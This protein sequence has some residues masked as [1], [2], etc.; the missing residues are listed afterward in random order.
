MDD[1]RFALRTLRNNKGFAVIAIMSLALGTGANTAIFSL[2]D[3]V[4]L[5]MLPVTHPE[6]LVFVGTNAVQMGSMKVSESIRAA[7]LEY[8]AQHA[9]TIDGIAGWDSRGKTGIGVNGAV[10]RGVVEFVSPAYYSVLGVQPFM[11]RVLNAADANSGGRVAVISYGYWQRRFGGDPAAVGKSFTLNS[12]PFTIVG[13]TP[14]EFYGLSASNAMDVAVPFQTQPQIR[15]G[16]MSSE[17]PKPGDFVGFAFARLKR[18]IA[19]SRVEAE[20]TPLLRQSVTAIEVETVKFQAVSNMH[21]ELKPASQGFSQVRNR[22]SEP[23]KVLMAVVAM[24]LLIACANVANLLLAKANGR[25]REIA[26]RMSLGSSRWRVVRQLL[27]ESVLLAIGGGA[28]GFVFAIW[29]RQAIIL[30][31][32]VEDASLNWDYRV[33]AFTAGVCLLSALLFG[34]APA[35]RA[36]TAIDFAEALKAGGSGR[37]AGRLRLGRALVATQVAL[38]LALLVGAGLFIFTFRNLDRIDLGYAR[39]DVLLV[40]LDPKL[41]GYSGARV[42]EVYRAAI[43]RIAELPGVRSVTMMGDRLMSGNVSLSSVFVPGYTPKNGEDPAHMWA[44]DTGV[45]PQFLATSGMQLIAGRDFDERDTEKSHKVALINET[46]ARHFWSTMNAVGRQFSGEPGDPPIEVVGVVR[47]VKYFGVR[48]TDHDIMFVPAAQYKEA[49]GQATLMVRTS[50]DP[51]RVIAGVQSAIREVDARVPMYDL[52]TLDEEVEKSLSLQRLLA[53]LSGFFGGLALLLAAIGLYGVLS[54]AVSQRTGEIGIRMAL[55]AQPRTVVGMILGE[56]S[57]LVLA[58][59]VA[60]I[61]LAL[62]GG[63]LVKSMLYGVESTDAASMA[64]AAAILLLAALVAAFFP[65]RRASR[66]DPMVAL[67]HE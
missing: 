18:G 5:R 31:A 34:T 14:R 47:N 26:I 67:R 51:S 23:L 10:E 32:G 63:R 42:G 9:K 16:K 64:A 56:T 35:L 53:L 66:V 60:G 45:G 12:V 38:S 15:S 43:D 39:K 17:V 28:L 33:I 2:V 62:A 21:I 8:F 4:M 40:T 41:A 44:I 58:G 11:G 3:A 27:T 55:G 52:I 30:V 22:F 20:L 48:Q 46:M 24:V 50:V 36:T 19:R 59:V 7:S 37:I 61:A 54:Y 29:A 13:V 25:R 49:P 57:R 6:E 1:L 65:A